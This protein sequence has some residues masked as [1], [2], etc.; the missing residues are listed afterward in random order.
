MAEQPLSKFKTQFERYGSMWKSIEIRALFALKEEHWVMLK[1][2]AYLRDTE[3]TQYGHKVMFDSPN[4]RAIVEHRKIDS[5][6]TLV[7]EMNTGKIHVG[8][9]DAVI[10]TGVPPQESS[11]GFYMS[12]SRSGKPPEKIFPYFT[13]YLS[14]GFVHEHVDENEINR[15]LYS[16]GYQGGLQEFSIAKTGEPVGG[17]YVIYFGIVAPIYLVAYA[18]SEPGYINAIVLC[19][20]GTKP[21]EITLRYELYGK[22]EAEILR[23]D[24]LVFLQDDK[25]FKEGNSYLER[26][27]AIPVEALSARL[28]VYYQSNEIPA[29]S[30][31]VL[32]GGVKATILTAFEAM[33]QIAGKGAYETLWDRFTR[34]L[35]VQSKAT[36]ADWFELG[37]WTLLTIS[38]LHVLHLGKVFGKGFDLPG[39][40]LLAFAGREKEIFLISCTIENKLSQ[41]IEPLI[42]QLNALRNKMLDWSVKGA[43]FA[44]IDRTD[45]TLGSFSDAAA[46][47]ISVLLRLEIQEILTIA[48]GA[49]ADASIKTLDVLK[50]PRLPTLGDSDI[51]QAYRAWL[52]EPEQE[53]I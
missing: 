18:E 34:Y 19:G 16:Y 13:Y 3:P 5:I 7:D 32:I 48:R 12:H 14:L 51:L 37:V 23:Q 25:H 35:G 52:Q 53:V 50:Q 17:S 40:D 49:S 27:L 47:D 28:L 20:E 8:D 30:F 33:G 22:T 9:T 36:D 45:I 44:P 43:I 15:L 31:N 6:W 26:K 21:D 2:M 42:S 29:D 38:G 41:K 46:S 24:K 39:V 11:F 1:V 4:L 10:A